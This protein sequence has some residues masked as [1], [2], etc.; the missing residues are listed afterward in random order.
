MA[1][2]A[3]ARSWL[4]RFATP[5]RPSRDGAGIR[6]EGAGDHDA[7]VDGAGNRPFRRQLWAGLGKPLTPQ[8]QPRNSLFP[9]FDTTWWW[10]S[11]AF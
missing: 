8:D 10:L 6:G 3:R 7:G 1:P 5:V 9:S 11:I 2:P 4:P